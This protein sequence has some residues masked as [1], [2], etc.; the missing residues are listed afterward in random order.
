MI[1]NADRIEQALEIE[2]ELFEIGHAEVVRDRAERKHHMVIRNV[3]AQ[4]FANAGRSVLQN[5][6]ALRK[7]DSRDPCTDKLSA[8][9][10]T[11]QRCCDVAGLKAAAG[12]LGEHRSKEQRVRLADERD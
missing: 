5:Y 3:P 11:A 2:G 1:T 9:Q 12:D 6:S 10:A 4:V 8:M 7:I